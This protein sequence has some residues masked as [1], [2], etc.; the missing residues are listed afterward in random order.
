MME[1]PDLGERHHHIVLVG[2]GNDLVVPDRAAGLDHGGD[3]CLVGY[4]H[5]VAEG[6]ECIGC[7]D[8][9]TEIESE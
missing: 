2:S 1:Q 7:H 9:A 3:A 4:L 8:G 5:A 6:E